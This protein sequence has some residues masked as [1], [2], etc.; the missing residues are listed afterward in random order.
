MGTPFDWFGIESHPDFCGNSATGKYKARKSAAGL[1]IT[2]QQFAN[3]MILRNV[4]LRYGFKP[5]KEEWWHFI[6]R[7]EPYPKTVFN[8][9]VKPINK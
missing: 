8:F 2:E 7:N 6:L 1:S 5:I 4:M 3:R 9:P